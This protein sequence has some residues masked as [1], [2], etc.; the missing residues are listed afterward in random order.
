MP[1]SKRRLA[2]AALGLAVILVVFLSGLLSPRPAP[3][4]TVTDLGVLPGYGDSHASAVNSRGDVA[5]S[6]SGP[7]SGHDQACLFQ[8]GKLTNIGTLP[9]ANG[10][11]ARGINAQGEITGEAEFPAAH[12]AFLY[13]KGKMQDLGT[14]PGF[15]DSKGVA[16][17]NQGEVTGSLMN[18]MGS[19][20]RHTF[21]YNHGKMTDLG[22]LPGASGSDT[23]SI[24]S[25][26]QIAGHCYMNFGRVH[27]AP[28]LYD[29]RT[30]TMTALSMPSP[31]SF[32]YAND[33]NDRGQVAGEISALDNIVHAAL[34]DNGR[35][36]DLGAPPGY[37]N[38]IAQG[39]NNRGEAV[40]RCSNDYNSVQ[41]FLRNHAGGN[42]ALRRYLDPDTT[43]A[44]VYR[45]GEMQDL[46]KLIPADADWT[47][48]NARSIND[49]GQI[50]GDGLHHG[51]RRGFLL[52][53]IR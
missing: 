5:G 28:F 40:G 53:Q 50:V 9:G 7:G 19:A 27:L 29:S 17:N 16:I 49:Q 15:T 38:S 33:V 43:R 11:S 20:Q 42:N 47:L 23:Q 12:H 41:I 18:L 48:E 51:Q 13:S 32:G 36:T 8:G 39:L 24:N 52:T 25:I 4:Y 31:Y 37:T 21:L 34:W 14:L 2:A 26:G 3:R 10:S 6:V 45:D 1:I 30:K 46:N 22:T 35:M 44:F